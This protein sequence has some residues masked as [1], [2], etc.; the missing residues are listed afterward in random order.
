[1]TDATRPKL[2]KLGPASLIVAGLLVLAT[3]PLIPLIIPSLA[4]AS[5]QAGLVAL[6][7]EGL[8]YEATWVLYL[9]SDLIF[10]VAFFALYYV[11]RPISARTAKV[12][13]GLNTVFVVI[14]V[15]LDI[16]LRLWLILLS[17]AYA[18][19]S[20]TPSQIVAT[21]DFAI[22]GSNQVALVATLF[23]FTALILV[24]YLMAKAPAF[25]KPVATLAL[26]PESCRCSSSRRSWPGRSN[27]RDSSTLRFCPSGS[28]ESMGRA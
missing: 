19:S 10:L 21:A 1:M 25:G 14:D 11:L 28:M 13:V 26:P 16:P 17:N 18:S 15:A 7:S 20:G 8:L 5:A 27:S 24:S 12:A 9:V 23:Q 22:S 3:I 2:R 6:E 4:P